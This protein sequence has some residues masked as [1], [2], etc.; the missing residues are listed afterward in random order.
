MNRKSAQPSNQ[1][2]RK[3]TNNKDMLT[4]KK[5]AE[6]INNKTL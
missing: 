2:G 6:R 4:D 3:T 5:I 1:W